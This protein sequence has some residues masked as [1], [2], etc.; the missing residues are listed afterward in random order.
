[1]GL[2]LTRG[3]EYAIRAM[4]YLSGRPAGEVSSLRDVGRE[5]NI[6]ESFLAK[7]FQSLVHSGL[8]V[9]QRGARGGF[10]LAR[11][12]SQITVAQVVQAIDGPV[13][14]NGCVL[15]P[16]TC[17]RSDSCTMHKVWISAQERIMGVLDE[18]SFADL[19]PSFVEKENAR[20]AA[21]A[22]SFT[23]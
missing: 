7:I 2:Q 1:M 10:A 12:G 22:R 16:D 4:M 3:S 6:P 21:G 15:W 9:S 19:V 17:E 8:V 13:S 5:Q 20:L 23:V 11:P 18:V 14:L